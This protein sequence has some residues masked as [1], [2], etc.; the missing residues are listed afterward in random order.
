M[1]RLGLGYEELKRINPR[2]ILASISGYGQVGPYREYLAYGPALVPLTGLASVTGFIGGKPE[3][4]GPSIP[5]PTAGMT[6]AWAVVSALEQREQ[7][8]RWRSPRYL[9]LGGDRRAGAGGLDAVRI[10]WHPAGPHGQSRPVDGTARLFRLSRRG[11]MGV[12]RVRGRCR[13]AEARGADRSR[14]WR[15]R[16]LSIP[17]GAKAERGR[18]GTDRLRMDRRQGPMGNHLAAPD[19]GRGLISELHHTRTSCATRI[20]MRAASSSG[21]S[22]RRSVAAPTWASRG[23]MTGAPTASAFQR[24]A[25]GR[26]RTRCCRRSSVTDAARIK[27]LARRRCAQVALM[28]RRTERPASAELCGLGSVEERHAQ[29]WSPQ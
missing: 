13:L 10:R 7:D 19:A 8:R 16:P 18:A 9:A 2:I 27:E 25:W 15:R 4:F 29:H 11:R 24:P 6:A 21:S 5:D 22:T 23:G 17:R 20:S 12:H 14:A 28:F 3:L 26:I 1:A